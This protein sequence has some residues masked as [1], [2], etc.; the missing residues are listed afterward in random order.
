M[1]QEDAKLDEV[2]SRLDSET[3]ERAIALFLEIVYRF[4]ID[5]RTGLDIDGQK[6]NSSE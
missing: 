6:S 3:R 5:S 4:V 1:D 2:W